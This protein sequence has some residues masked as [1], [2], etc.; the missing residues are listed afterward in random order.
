MMILKLAPFLLLLV[1]GGTPIGELTSLIELHSNIQS[2]LV[3]VRSESEVIRQQFETAKHRIDA[4]NSCLGQMPAPV[5]TESNENIPFSINEKF[6]SIMKAINGKSG[7][8]L[9]AILFQSRRAFGEE[10]FRI[11]S[12]HLYKMSFSA[13]I[14]HSEDVNILSTSERYLIDE[15]TGIQSHIDYM[16]KN[17][18]PG[19]PDVKDKVSRIMTEL[20]RE[21]NFLQKRYSAI[22]MAIDT[23][24]ERQWFPNIAT[25]ISSLAKQSQLIASF[26]KEPWISQTTLVECIAASISVRGYGERGRR[27]LHDISSKFVASR[28]RV[29][30][31]TI[32]YLESYLRNS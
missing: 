2:K 25:V 31:A 32:Q 4:L 23:V 21:R 3:D 10:T 18:Y 7:L 13:I 1:N 22:R 16:L 27:N 15:L 28:E 11:L 14:E 6:A 20:A 8:E 5:T 29:I 30:D 19:R 9:C 24:Y 12:A 26:Y 17:I